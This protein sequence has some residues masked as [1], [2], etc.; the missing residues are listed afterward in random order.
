MDIK[1][2]CVLIIDP[3]QKKNKSLIKALSQHGIE[4]VHQAAHYRLIDDLLKKH[5]FNLIFLADDYMDSKSG[6]ALAFLQECA[7]TKTVSKWLHTAEDEQAAQALMDK[8]LQ[9]VLTYK[10]GTL[11]NLDSVLEPFI[12]KARGAELIQHIQGNSFFKNF[13][14]AELKEILTKSQPCY[15]EV[16]EQVLCPESTPDCFF[17]LLNGSITHILTDGKTNLISTTFN[18]QAVLRAVEALE[19]EAATLGRYYATTQCTCLRVKGELAHSPNSTLYHLAR[20]RI[21]PPLALWSQRLFQLC[22]QVINAAQIRIHYDQLQSPSIEM[23]LLLPTAKK[24]TVI[25][26]KE[27]KNP[28][29]GKKVLVI[30]PS[31]EKNG[32]IKELGKALEFA[33]LQF[34]VHYK[35]AEA[36]LEKGAF[37][38]IIIGDD[39]LDSGAEQAFSFLRKNT[40]SCKTDVCINLSEG[41]KNE[42][43]FLA[44]KGLVGVISHPA[45]NEALSELFESD[46]DELLTLSSEEGD[47]SVSHLVEKSSFFK[48]LSTEECQQIM[49]FSRP[50]LFSPGEKVIEGHSSTDDVYVLLKGEVYRVLETKDDHDIALTFAEGA[51]M[52]ASSFVSDSPYIRGKYIAKTE[53]VILRIRTELLHEA[54]AEFASKLLSRFVNTVAHVGKSS[55]LLLSVLLGTL[56]GKINFDQ[57]EVRGITHGG[58]LP[59]TAAELEAAEQGKKSSRASMLDDLDMIDD[60][61]SMTNPFT[62][63]TGIAESYSQEITSQDEYDVLLRKIHLRSEFI[64][65]KFPSSIIDLIHNKMYGYWTGGKLAKINPHKLWNTKSFMP[66]SPTLKNALH[67]VVA[68]SNGDKLFKEAYLDLTESHRVVGLPQIGCAGSF[69]GND[70]AIERYIQEKPPASA[71]KLDFDIPIEREFEG[72][73]CIEFL[74]HTAADV[75]AETLFLIF[76]NE[77][78][79]NTRLFRD[80]Y[81]MHQMISV[82]KG[83]AFDPEDLATMFT[84]PEA[85]LEE[86]NM[87]LSKKAYKDKGFYQGQTVFLPDYTLCYEKTNLENSGYLFGLIGVFA[88]V[89]P[90]YSG[91]VWGSKGGAEGAVRAARAMFGMK[92]AQ[93]AKDIAQAINWADD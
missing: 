1:D 50:E 68:A 79:K 23:E 13:T 7:N 47:N 52:G 43:Q 63:P 41:K 92:G 22:E 8:G 26:V 44:G 16:G 28:A 35:L 5:T 60:H 58:T 62:K 49:G 20:S 34:A 24:D 54:S 78:G 73:P 61:V 15:F 86:K 53:C 70:D 57:V 66:G 69:L 32:H 88:R 51:V 71:I 87:L 17:I 89:G 3:N 93:S 21:A 29:K 25:T 75:R 10:E 4:N 45:T 30:D 80:N 82:V 42:F 72:N 2:L 90:D 83:L 56:G 6:T 76:D 36:Q 12:K 81:P 18:D 11:A 9:G 91:L 38:L 37:D 33:D 74:T 84:E 64:C 46:D 31:P 48:G 40:N 59:K 65:G 14:K 27:E 67:L 19:G 55:F 39:F 85:R 77:D